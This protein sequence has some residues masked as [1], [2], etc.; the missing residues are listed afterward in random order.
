[1]NLTGKEIVALGIVTGPIEK[2]NIQMH[3]VDLNVIKIQHIG[4]KGHIPKEGKTE[5]PEYEDVETYPIK[6]GWN[7]DKTDLIEVQWWMLEPGMYN[8]EFAQGCS[9]PSN[10]RLR[11]VQRS[12]LLRCGGMLASSFFDSGF[13]TNSVGTCIIVMQRLTIE[14]GAR[15]AT[16]YTEESN[17]VAPEDLYGAKGKNSQWQSDSQRKAE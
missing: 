1:M 8:V 13:K 16:A 6:I 17:E 2:D 12:S 7:K 14:K 15:I 9:I 10:K 4:P 5:L 11:L 3:S